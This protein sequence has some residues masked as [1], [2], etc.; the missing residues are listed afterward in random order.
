MDDNLA[1]SVLTKVKAWSSTNDE[2]ILEL[3]ALGDSDL[4]EFLNDGLDIVGDV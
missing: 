1:C 4:D 3:K 2:L